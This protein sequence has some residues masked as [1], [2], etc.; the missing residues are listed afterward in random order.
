MRRTILLIVLSGMTANAFGGNASPEGSLAH[1]VLRVDRCWTKVAGGKATLTVSPLRRIKDIFEGEFDM[2]V[3][4][5]FFK[6]DKGKLAITVSDDLMAKVCAG[7]PVG[8]IGTATTKAGKGSVVR[9]INAEA[10]PV[11]ALHGMLKVWLTV[12]EREL[13]FQT[14]YWFVE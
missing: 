10:T 6:N 11:D 13:V 7:S 4:P 9:Q 5:Y 14:K 12:D 3:A 8:I 1:R 2:K